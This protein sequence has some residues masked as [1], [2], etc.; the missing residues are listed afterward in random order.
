MSGQSHK[1]VLA[2]ASPRRLDLLAQIGITPDFVTPADINEDPILGELPRD[3]A[4]RLA[5]EK[6]A[7]IAGQTPDHIILATDT[8]VGVGRRILPKTETAD[9]ARKCLELMSGRGHRVYTGVAVIKAN[10]DMMSRVVE[11][12]LKMKRL[13]ADELQEY[14]DSEEWKGK[15]GGYGIQGRAGAFIPT[16]IGSY[17]NV[18]GLPLFETRNLLM[19]AG[20]FS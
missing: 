12:R 11:T 17:T 2:S 7:K 10:G 16:L 1:L 15:A 4:L 5:Q 20:Y 9:Q 18:V 6:A 13:S 3:H 14:L 8:V 19:G